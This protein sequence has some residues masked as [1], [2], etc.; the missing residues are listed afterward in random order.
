MIEIP[1]THG[2]FAVVDDDDSDLLHFRWH[3]SKYGY[4]L[5]ATKVKEKRTSKKVPMHRIILER[6]VGRPL[7]KSELTDHRDQNR[8]NN[9]RDNLRI[10]TRA[11]NMWNSGKSITGKNP[12]K[13]VSLHRG[14][15]DA[16][17]GFH[18]KMHH[19][20]SYKTPEEAAH[21]VNDAATRFYGEYAP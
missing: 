12:Y 5:R 4:A 19:L 21:A 16:R 2:K 3:Y 7:L 13:G 9:Q 6:K 8:L 11:Q 10:A 18:G 1:L 17:I 15:W 14:V 20:G